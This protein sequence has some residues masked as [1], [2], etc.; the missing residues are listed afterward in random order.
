MTR[1]T[2]CLRRVQFGGLTTSVTVLWAIDAGRHSGELLA[3]HQDGLLETV[4]RPLAFV[5][6][7]PQ[8]HA[9]EALASD[10]LDH[11]CDRIDHFSGRGGLGQ[12]PG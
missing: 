12:Q 5:P 1:R 11:R 2:W 7:A 3:Q 4:S 10:P 9:K 6:V 8:R